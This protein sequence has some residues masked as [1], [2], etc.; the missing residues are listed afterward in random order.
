MVDAYATLRANLHAGNL[1]PSTSRRYR[2][3]LTTPIVF[4][5]EAAQPF[6]DRCV[7]VPS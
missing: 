7:T 1:G 2:K 4:R 5:P 3:A 6:D